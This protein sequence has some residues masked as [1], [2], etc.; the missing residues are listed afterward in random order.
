MDAFVSVFAEKPAVL[1]PDA[2]ILALV[3][4]LELCFR[5]ASGAGTD[6]FFSA[7]AE[8]PAVLPPDAEI[9]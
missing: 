3:F 1:P 5:T 9:L 2:E 8:K 6:A 4:E 7:F